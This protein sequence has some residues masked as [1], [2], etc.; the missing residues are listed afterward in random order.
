MPHNR[1]LSIPSKL[2]EGTPLWSRL[3]VFRHTILL[4][5][6]VLS[7][8]E[9]IPRGFLEEWI[10]RE[11]CLKL[12]REPHPERFYYITFWGSARS[13]RLTKSLLLTAFVL[14]LW[15]TILAV[16]R[17]IISGFKRDFALFLAL[18]ANC[19]VHLPWPAKSTTTA[20]LISHHVSSHS[21]GHQILQYI[22]VPF[23][24]ALKV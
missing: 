16:Y 18:R 4:Y 7:T 13:K 17:T 9:G 22:W 23:F 11:I 14:A 2:H 8:Q 19:L 5:R 20:T 21:Y 6:G 10:V 24:S 15:I 12:L 1:I 3:V